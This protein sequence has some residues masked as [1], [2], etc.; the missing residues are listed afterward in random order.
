[1]IDQRIEKLAEW[2]RIIRSSTWRSLYD[3]ILETNPWF[4]AESIELALEGLNNYLDYQKLKDWSAPYAQY[5]GS[6]KSVGIIMAGNLPLVGVHDLICGYVSGHRT[7]VKTSSQDSL[8]VRSLWNEMIRLDPSVTSRVTFVNSLR[9]RQ[10]D[11][12]IATGSDNTSRYFK[13]YYRDIPCI[14]RG[15]RTSVAI[16]NGS[17]SGE[18]L[19]GLGMDMY[20]YF[21]R[22]CRNVSK[23]LVPVGYE[24]H[25][26]FDRTSKY[27]YLTNNP[28]Y[29]SNYKYQ[30]ALKTLQAINFADT[31]YSLFFEHSDLVSPLSVINYEFYKSL[32]HVDSSI[33]EQSTEIQCVASSNGWYTNSLPFGSLQRPNLEDY[34]DN[35]DTMEFLMEL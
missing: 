26:L 21:G 35:I 19:E 16:L 11:A 34:A 32:E 31:G 20:S 1:M 29:L 17:E 4:T 10:V 33:S 18:Q 12:L 9:T 24:F 5:K 30:K 23:L 7:L 22:G 14:I 15:N 28:G 13:Y 2:G 8:L 6:S 25:G 3:A 27:S